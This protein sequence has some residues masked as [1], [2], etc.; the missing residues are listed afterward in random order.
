MGVIIH[1]IYIFKFKIEF[2]ERTEQLLASAWCFS[3]SLA[4]ELLTRCL[5]SDVCEKQERGHRPT[6]SIQGI[7]TG[8]GIINK[9]RTKMHVLGARWCQWCLSTVSIPF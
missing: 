5:L 4:A 9:E 3:C 8:Y 7:H 1:N 6:A 2:K